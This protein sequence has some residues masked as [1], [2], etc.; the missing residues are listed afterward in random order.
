MIR[1]K[2]VD[3]QP[4]GHDEVDDGAEF[5]TEPCGDKPYYVVAT[6][7]DATPGPFQVKTGPVYDLING[8]ITYSVGYIPAAEIAAAKIVAIKTEREARLA[9]GFDYDFGNGRGVHHI[10]TTRQDLIGWGEVTDLAEALRAAGQAAAIIN[11][12]TD[13][14]SCQV[15]PDE[16]AEIQIAAAA[17]RQPI[18][19]ASFVA[20][21]A[22]A[23][24]LASGDAAALAAFDPAGW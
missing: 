19:G 8:T 3:G 2:V 15:T 16:W 4:V 24:L 9:A 14:G 7:T 17:V 1:I 12:M 10:G 11:M 22:I 20:Q 13:T 5:L 6:L 21:A 23:A 18:W